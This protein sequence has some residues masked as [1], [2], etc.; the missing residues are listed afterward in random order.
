MPEVIVQKEEGFDLCLEDILFKGLGFG[1]FQIRSFNKRK[2]TKGFPLKSGEVL[3]LEERQTLCS[4]YLCFGS[5]LM[6][7]THMH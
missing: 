4:C 1:R 6:K 7:Y 2:L 3:S 5:S